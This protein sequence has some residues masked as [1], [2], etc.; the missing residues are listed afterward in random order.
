[1]PS[2]SNAEHANTDVQKP[3]EDQTDLEAASKQDKKGT[4]PLFGNTTFK[5]LSRAQRTE[6]VEQVLKVAYIYSCDSRHRAVLV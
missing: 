2:K 5:K 6:L 4:S 3:A 1:M